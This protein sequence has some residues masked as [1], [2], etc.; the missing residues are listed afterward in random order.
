MQKRL[1]KISINRRHPR[2]GPWGSLLALFGLAA[3]LVAGC[4]DT[5]PLCLVSVS[6]VTPTP[7]HALTVFAP[8]EHT[9]RFENVA[10]NSTGAAQLAPAGMH[11]KTRLMLSPTKGRDIT[12]TVVL[13]TLVPPTFRGRVIFQIE[14]QNQVRGF[15]LPEIKGDEEGEIPWDNP[16][17]W[18]AAPTIPGMSGEE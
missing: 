9:L 18:T 10:P 5:R 6:N 1:Q 15:V 12:M 8:Q 3:F 13:P 16:P 7:V 17:T 2:S 14:E 11:E 4:A